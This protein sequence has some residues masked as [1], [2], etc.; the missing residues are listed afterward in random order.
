MAN[1]GLPS[2]ASLPASSASLHRLPSRTAK[3]HPQAAKRWQPLHWHA[4]GRIWSDFPRMRPQSTPSNSKAVVASTLAGPRAYLVRFPADAP[5]KHTL[6]QQSGG[7]LHTGRPNGVFGA[8]SRGC[9][10]KAHPQAAKRWQPPHWQAQRRIWSDLPRMHPQT[11]PHPSSSSWYS[12]P[13]R[14]L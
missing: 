9:T 7:S 14:V 6:K 11:R 1:R 2:P 5:P 3:A 12:R 13:M 10:P 8:I 4:Q